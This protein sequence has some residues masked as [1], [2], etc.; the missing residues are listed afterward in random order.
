[1]TLQHAYIDGDILVHRA[2]WNSNRSDV[3]RKINVA[4]VAIMEHLEHALSSQ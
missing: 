4:I 2:I 1:M 3:K